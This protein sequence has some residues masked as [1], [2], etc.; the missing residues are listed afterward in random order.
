MFFLDPVVIVAACGAGLPG[1]PSDLLLPDIPWSEPSNGLSGC[2]VAEATSVP[3]GGTVRGELLFRYDGLLTGK[4]FAELIRDDCTEDWMALLRGVRSGG[5]HV[6]RETPIPFPHCHLFDDPVKL[7]HGAMSSHGVLFRLLTPGGIQIP[8]GVYD[9]HIAYWNDGNAENPEVDMRTDS[10]DSA[11]RWWRGMLNAPP[12]RI[13]VVPREADTTKVDLPTAVLLSWQEPHRQLVGDWDPESWET[14][15]ILSTPGWHV[16]VRFEPTLVIGGRSFTLARLSREEHEVFRT[17]WHGGMVARSGLPGRGV[18]DRMSLGRPPDGSERP[19]EVPE[20]R[21]RGYVYES[22][23]WRS[24]G[25]G[26]RDRVLRE[27]DVPARWP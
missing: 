15:D 14:V 13:R 9:L 24:W 27:W 6:R 3:Y 8:P 22:L 4:P 21:L 7:V 10:P 16:I 5:L 25:I 1:P 18:R 19:F 11:D 2:F 12:V 23:E 26:D 17:L 20:I